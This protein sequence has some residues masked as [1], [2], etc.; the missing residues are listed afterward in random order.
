MIKVCVAG[1]TGW[2]GSAVAKGVLESKDFQLVSA[3]ARKSAG[4]DVG[5]ALGLPKAGV[6]IED[7]LDRALARP[8]DV[9]IEYTHASTVKQHV[10]TA[11]GKG[12]RV[13]IGSSGLTAADFEEIEKIAREKKL[14]VI[15][16]GNFSITAVWRRASPCKQ[17]AICL[18]GR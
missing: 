15:A 11:L 5:E 10:L 14:G 8:V 1:V 13:V 12:I 16:A 9:L 4:K 3:V 2:T 6:V 7:S 17:R 18:P